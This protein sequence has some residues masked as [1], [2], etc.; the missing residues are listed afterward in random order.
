[1][2]PLNRPSPSSYPH[3]NALFVPRECLLFFLRVEGIK[4]RISSYR[5]NPSH[6]SL[7]VQGCVQF[8]S[9]AISLDQAFPCGVSGVTV[10]VHCRRHWRGWALTLSSGMFWHYAVS[11]V[12]NHSCCNKDG[13]CCEPLAFAYTEVHKMSCLT[14]TLPLILW[15]ALLEDDQPFLGDAHCIGLSEGLHLLH[16]RT[17]FYMIKGHLARN[18]VLTDSLVLQPEMGQQILWDS[19]SFS[20]IARREGAYSVTWAK[21]AIEGN[22]VL[23]TAACLL[24]LF[25]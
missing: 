24:G 6:I 16:P 10:S 18:L 3:C 20:E 23:M 5:Q 17:L 25:P 22:E 7:R 8:G 4:K 11:H 12:S 13:F 15:D 21:V 9:L 1:M 2:C 19:T 14:R